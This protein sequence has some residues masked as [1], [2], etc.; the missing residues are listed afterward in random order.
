VTHLFDLYS[1]GIVAYEVFTGSVPFAHVELMPFLTMH[2]S[3]PPPP[4][5]ERNPAIPPPLE[6]VILR[7]LEK[8]PARRVPSCEELGGSSI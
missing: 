3:A 8:D 6:A 2:L 1:L 5:S 4:P 7:L